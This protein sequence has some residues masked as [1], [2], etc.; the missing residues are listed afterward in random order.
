QR[1]PHSHQKSHSKE[2]NPNPIQTH[3]ANLTLN[4][5]I[6]PTGHIIISL[7]SVLYLSPIPYLKD[8]SVIKLIHQPYY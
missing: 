7:F 6:S 8:F 5:P 2:R 1:L 3:T 4:F